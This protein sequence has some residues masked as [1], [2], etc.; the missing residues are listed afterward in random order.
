MIKYSSMRVKCD[1]SDH[2][3]WLS[4]FKS[5]NNE[6]PKIVPPNQLQAVYRYLLNHYTT[7]KEDKYWQ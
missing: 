3:Y 2:K 1:N 5:T 7:L 4:E 6:S